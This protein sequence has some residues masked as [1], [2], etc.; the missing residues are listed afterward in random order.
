MC[1]AKIGGKR[2]IRVKSVQTICV[3]SVRNNLREKNSDAMDFLNTDDTDDTDFIVL[4]FIVNLEF[5]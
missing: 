3:K 2:K 4:F 1:S 5:F